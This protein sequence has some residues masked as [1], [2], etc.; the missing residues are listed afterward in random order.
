MVVGDG[1]NAPIAREWVRVRIAG[2][3]HFSVLA[4]LGEAREAAV[5]E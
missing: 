2:A 1:R 3:C 5:A 4:E